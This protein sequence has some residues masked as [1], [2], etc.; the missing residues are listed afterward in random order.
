MFRYGV[1][2]PKTKI[3]WNFIDKLEKD[4]EVLA[5]SKKIGII[6]TETLSSVKRA[7][8]NIPGFNLLNLKSI[9]TYDVA[10]QNFLIFTKEAVTSLK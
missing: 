6:S 4:I 3:G 1:I 8:G 7:F 9:N 2:E 5:K 10:N